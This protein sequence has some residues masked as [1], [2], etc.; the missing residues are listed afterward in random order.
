M[1]GFSV[2]GIGSIGGLSPDIS[3]TLG[4]NASIGGSALQLAES[5]FTTFSQMSSASTL[6]TKAIVDNSMITG[7]NS[8]LRKMPPVFG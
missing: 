4:L 2:G 6:S 7:L 3:E 8:Q 1:T 5:Q